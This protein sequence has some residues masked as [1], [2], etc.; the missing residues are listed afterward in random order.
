MVLRNVIK[1]DNLQDP[2][3]PVAGILQK[4]DPVQLMTQYAIPDFTDLQSFLA[5]IARRRGKLKRG[6][7]PDLD[8]AAKIVLYDWVT[9]KIPYSTLPPNYMQQD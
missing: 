1:I 7:T 8:S 6:G 4:V 2:F 9:G 5:N 3:T